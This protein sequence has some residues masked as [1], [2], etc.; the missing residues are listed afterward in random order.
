MKSVA[1]LDDDLMNMISACINKDVICIDEAQFMK[2]LVEFCEM[3]ATNRNK[4]II[5]AALD[6]DFKMNP[7]PVIAQILSRCERVKKLRSICVECGADA[8]FTRKVGGSKNTIVEVGGADL[9]VPTCR[10]HHDGKLSKD[11]L[12]RM[13]STNERIKLMKSI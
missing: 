6:G 8:A 5:I 10:K 4:H 9:Y 11:T 2:N 12:P 3:M 7:F 1:V 13:K